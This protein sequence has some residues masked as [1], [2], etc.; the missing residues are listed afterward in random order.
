MAYRVF[1]QVP[2][3]ILCVEL[4]GAI[5]VLQLSSGC[6]SMR[7]AAKTRTAADAA[8]ETFRQVFPEALAD[9]STV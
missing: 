1:W 9:E 8:L 4:E 3:Q 2:Q 7:A 5:V 6:L